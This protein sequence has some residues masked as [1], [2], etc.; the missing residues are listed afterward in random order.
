LR[1]VHEERVLKTK[2]RILAGLLCL[3]LLFAACMPR[4]GSDKEGSDPQAH[5]IDRKTLLDKI[6]GGWVGQMAGVAWGG[7]TEFSCQGEIMQGEA[8]WKPMD[9]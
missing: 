5:S 2:S 9:Q 3:A 6:E 7:R 4:V 8:S 1:I